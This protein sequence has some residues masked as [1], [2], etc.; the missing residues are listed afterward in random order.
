MI[1][2]CSPRSNIRKKC[3]SPR[4]HTHSFQP[5]PEYEANRR[6]GSSNWVQPRQRVGRDLRD[7]GDFP[8][9]V[10]ADAAKVRMGL[11]QFDNVIVHEEAFDFTTEVIAESLLRPDSWQSR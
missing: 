2:Y 6:E 5:P 9:D 3:S 1:P 10:V 7:A 11:Q 4:V 8:Q